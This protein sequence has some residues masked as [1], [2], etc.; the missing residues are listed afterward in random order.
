MHKTETQD[1][2]DLNIWFRDENRYIRE[3]KNSII[4]Y[5]SSEMK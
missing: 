3:N 1:R 2:K 4:F 5:L